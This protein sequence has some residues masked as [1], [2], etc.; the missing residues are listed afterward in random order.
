MALCNHR[1]NLTDDQLKALFSAGGY[2]GVNFYPHF[3]RED[4]KAGIEDVCDHVM[5][6]LSLGGEDH[7]GFG[8]D[9]DGIEVKPEGL[10]GPQDFPSL[11]SALR[12]R[13]LSEAQLEKIAGKN[14]LCYYDRIDP[15]V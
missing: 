11:L 7:V 5:H 3:L 15:R 9:F 10:N 8:S 2:V 6:M 13:G 4:G 1:R 14:L 12:A